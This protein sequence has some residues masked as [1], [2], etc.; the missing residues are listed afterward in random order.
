[1]QQGRYEEAIRTFRELLARNPE[2]AGWIACLGYAYAAAGRR[3]EARKIL[4]ELEEL[5][6]R[7]YVYPSLWA[8]ISTALG[9]KDKAFER[10]EKGHEGRD[11]AMPFT[12]VDP[13]F[14]D[15]RTDPRFQDLLASNE[16]PAVNRVRARSMK[17]PNPFLTCP[18]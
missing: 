2:D 16:I 6:S 1:M 12:K 18:Q 7:A 17:F 15:L 14:A 5:S 11:V 8:I 9:E 10:L 3:D 4:D 13:W